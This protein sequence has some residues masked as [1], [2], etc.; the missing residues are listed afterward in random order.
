M[1]RLVLPGVRTGLCISKLL[2]FCVPTHCPKPEGGGG[3]LAPLL[4]GSLPGE[5]AHGVAVAQLLDLGASDLMKRGRS[6]SHPGQTCHQR[7][8][9]Q[10]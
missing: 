5:S 3:G 2:A 4:R 6:P 1:R 7:L 8:P 10:T 9:A